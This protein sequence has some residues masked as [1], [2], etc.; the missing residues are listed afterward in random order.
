MKIF[1]QYILPA[2]ISA[3]TSLLVV[4]LTIKGNLD[5]LVK[6]KR[7]QIEL[8]EQIYIDKKVL[9]NLNQTA[10]LLPDCYR[11]EMSYEMHKI[12]FYFHNRKNSGSNEE[13]HMVIIHI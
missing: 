11:N 1:L 5:K 4:W 10:A 12:N 2:L 13:T 8:E 3:L 7:Y 6:E 9:E